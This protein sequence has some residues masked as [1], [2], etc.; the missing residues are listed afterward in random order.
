[1]NRLTTIFLCL[2]MVAPMLTFGDEKV[3]A[4]NLILLP[5]KNDP[6]VSF[7]IWFKVGSQNDPAGKEGLASITAS[8]LTDAATQKNSY[9]QVLDKL[10]PLAS[11]YNASTSADVCCRYFT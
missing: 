5:V 3:P 9:E 8:M 6:T 4:D 10:F 7:R 11:N 1:M 2:C